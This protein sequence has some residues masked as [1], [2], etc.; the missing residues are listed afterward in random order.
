VKSIVR[1]TKT[2]VLADGSQLPYTKLALTTGGR[3]RRLPQAQTAQG[4]TPDNLHYVRT[5]QDGLRLR[6]QFR[7][8]ARLVVIGGGYIGLEVAAAAISHGLKVVVLEAANRLLARVTSPEM[9]G[10]YE[11]AHQQAGVEVRTGSPVAGFEFTRDGRC[12]TGVSCS[13]GS[14]RD[15]DLVVAGVGLQPNTEL[16]HDA[17]LVVDDGIVVDEFAR[18]SDPDIVAAGDCT[19]HP[20]EFVDRMVRLESVP[21]ALEQAR[22]AAA[23]LCGLERPYR[24]L[25][26]F[27]SDQYDLKLRSAGLMEGH[28]TLVVRGVMADRAFSVFYLHGHRVLAADTVNRPQDF[29]LVKRLVAE[30]IEV[31]PVALADT[32]VPMKDLLKAP[33]LSQ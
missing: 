32:A 26:W 30:R 15:V 14:R 25:P 11:R 3:P 21:N 1:D 18:T 23:T 16:A 29:M 31:D 2:L 6:A 7:P 28:D 17:G 33:A 5:A 8:G 27:W 13:D 22:S 4:E 24:A 20:C 12:I 9:S 19:K 10:F